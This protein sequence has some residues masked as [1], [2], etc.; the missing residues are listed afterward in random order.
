M[1]ESGRFVVVDEVVAVARKRR[2]RGLYD[3]LATDAAFLLNNKLLILLA[4]C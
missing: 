2:H 4:M 1:P 3:C